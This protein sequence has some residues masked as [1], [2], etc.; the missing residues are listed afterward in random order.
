MATTDRRGVS[1]DAT[2]TPI[3]GGPNPGL[4]IKAPALVATTANITLSGLQTIDGIALADGNRVLVW[5]QTD[6]KLNGIY[7]ASSG[8][9]TRAIDADSNDQ[10][11]AGL[12]VRIARGTNYAGYL[13]R[14]TTADPI[15]LGTTA[16]GFSSA[17]PSAQFVGG[18]IS[19]A[20]IDD[21]NSAIL[22][23]SNFTLEDNADATK[24]A[25]FE[26][27]GIAAGTLR[28]YSV[29]DANTTL[30]GTDVAQVL[31]N[32]TIDGDANTIVDIGNASLKPVGAATLKG[33]PAAASGAV[34]DF[35]IQSLTALSSPHGTLDFLLAYDHVSG[36]LRKVAPNSLA[37]LISVN[38][39]A[40]LKA[41]DKTSRTI[42]QVN[43][44]Y[45]VGDCRPRTYYYDSS[46]T[47]SSD[48][49]GS[50]IVGSDGGRW[51][52]IGQRI[53]TMKMFGVKE[54]GTDQSAAMLN[55]ITVA[56]AANVPLEWDGSFS[57][58]GIIVASLSGMHW[59]GRGGVVG[60]ATGATDAL[61]QLVNCTDLSVE[62]RLVVNGNYNTNYS[63]GLH[64]YTTGG[65][66]L[67]F[68]N[69]ENVIFQGCKIAWAFG[70]TAL[71]DA[72]VS[73]I[74]MFG[75]RTVGCPGIGIG[76]G[77]NTVVSTEGS[78]WFSSYG[79]GGG[80]WTAL[81]I[82][83]VEAKG[84]TIN[85][86][87]G[88]LLRTEDTT[89][90]LL[91]VSGLVS[92]SGH[93]YGNVNVKGAV[94]EAANILA[95]TTVGGATA[96]AGG[97][98][99]ISGGD[100]MVLTSDV[101]G[102]AVQT[103]STYVGEVTITGNS[104]FASVSRTQPNVNAGNAACKVTVDMKSFGTNC[105]QGYAGLSG[106]VQVVI[107][108]DSG[109][110]TVVN[111]TVTAQSGSI[112]TIGS[113][114]GRYQRRGKTVLYQGDV[115]I[116]TAGTAAQACLVSLPFTAASNNYVGSSY[117][118]GLTAKS[119]AA[120]IVPSVTGAT[121]VALRDAT[122]ATYFANGAKFTF[123]IEYELP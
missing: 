5:Q 113:K 71:P 40:G 78:T 33:N 102:G 7:N 85:L 96:P 120:A 109:A 52:L 1:V 83:G 92:G 12:Q 63:Y 74:N 91:L 49:A 62:G 2:D 89:G 11:A 28:T 24:R 41:V 45:A 8:P 80:S 75:G 119:G 43:G 114:T 13:F 98:I 18:T 27:S 68:L 37:P 67:Q 108:G 105:L 118:Y 53:W 54:D 65:G 95:A 123:E 103:D 48:N 87:G 58:N 17:L 61:I 100:R 104:G 84:A 117:E 10:W 115:Q 39:I 60:I 32:K 86:N 36:Q 6:A 79:T 38:T 26:L 34:E 3:A 30:V 73:E 94:I 122:G 90:Q 46:D 4:A 42:A 111:P 21:T 14:L 70:S 82:V 69:L 9:W 44:Y 112:T 72:T 93:V 116:T 47:T 23:D 29:P 55:A 101:T 64:G 56:A 97:S 16:L 35:T 25:R 51:K 31:T 20:T 66:T 106:G 77:K 76:I 81:P 22:K 88:E 50:V 121:V 59:I 57:I 110:W 19:G 15:I 107:D 99:Q